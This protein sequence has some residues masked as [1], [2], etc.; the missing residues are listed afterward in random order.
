VHAVYKLKK[1]GA[2]DILGQIKV[3]NILYI[4]GKDMA[5]KYDLHHWDN[6]HIKNQVIVILCALKN[7]IFL[8]ID[9]NKSVATFQIRKNED[10]LHFEKL[11]TL[12]SVSGKG[13]GTFCMQQIEEIAK[14]HGCSRVSMEVYTNSEHAIKFYE[15]RGYK[16]IGETNTLKYTEVKMEKIL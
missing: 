12:P 16:I 4:S 2:I 10:V 15:Q 3:S 8:V 11:A 7:S 9:G 5:Q 1:I 13:V 14:N 6:S